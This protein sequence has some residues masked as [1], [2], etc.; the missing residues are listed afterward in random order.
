MIP[1]PFLV[2]L[3][4]FALTSCG[5]RGAESSR[6]HDVADAETEADGRQVRVR[7]SGIALEKPTDPARPARRLAAL[8]VVAR[9]GSAIAPWVCEA[10]LETRSPLTRHQPNVTSMS[11]HDFAREVQ[12]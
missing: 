9:V 5:S 10:E 6:R 3:A 11:P 1:A 7:L 2:A 8:T 4:A 12:P